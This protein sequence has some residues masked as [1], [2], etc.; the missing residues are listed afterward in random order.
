M[1]MVIEVDSVVGEAS[2]VEGVSEAADSGEGVAGEKFC[3]GI[4]VIL[5]RRSARR[6]PPNIEVSKRFAESMEYWKVHM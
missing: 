5:A 1:G 3:G 2:E 6:I 4:S